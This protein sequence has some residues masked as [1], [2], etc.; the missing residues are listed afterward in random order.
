MTMW[1]IQGGV[2]VTSARIQKTCKTN[3]EKDEPCLEDGM[4]Y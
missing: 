3:E 2:A 1:N 4:E